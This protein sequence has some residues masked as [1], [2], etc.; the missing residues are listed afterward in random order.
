MPWPSLVSK[1]ASACY[2]SFSRH[3]WLQLDQM[4]KLYAFHLCSVGTLPLSLSSSI[5][6]SSFFFNTYHLSPSSSEI[7]GSSSVFSKNPP[8][9]NDGALT[10]TLTG[11][12]LASWALGTVVK[13]QVGNG[14]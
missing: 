7:R 13:R 3:S 9:L 14:P 4:A 11:H 6:N 2:P 12:P 10:S 5:L 1:A 8:S